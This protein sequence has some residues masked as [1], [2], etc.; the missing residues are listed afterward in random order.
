MWERLT[1]ATWRWKPVPKLGLIASDEVTKA[2]LTAQ[3]RGE[4][5]KPLQQMLMPAMNEGDY[6]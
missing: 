6:H 3:G 2:Y 5:F 1:L 4:E